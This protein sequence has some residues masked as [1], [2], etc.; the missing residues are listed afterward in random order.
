M[1]FRLLLTAASGALDLWVGIP[2]GFALGL[3]AVLV[4]AAAVS[5][6]L[7][8]AMLAFFAGSWLRRWIQGN[9]WLAKRRRRVEHAMKRYG[10]PGVALQAPLLTGTPTAI[11]VALALGAPVRSLLRWMIPSVVLWGAVF[12][13]A[14]A[15]G[16][17]FLWD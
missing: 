7:G 11:V 14:A 9:R 4:W 8:V 2:V 3:P 5:G 17:S 1:L 12:T 10:V 6:N 15:L 16:V 13:G